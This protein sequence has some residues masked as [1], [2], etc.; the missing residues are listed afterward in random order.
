MRN[1]SL[2]RRLSVSLI[3]LTT[4]GVVAVSLAVSM[5]LGR[6]L[7]SSVDEQLTTATGRP[8][9][10]TQLPPIAVPDT[11]KSPQLPS[12]FVITVLSPDGTALRQ[13]RGSLAAKVPPPDLTG[14]T[15]TFVRA[16]EGEPRTVQGEGGGAPYRAVAYFDARSQQSVVLAISLVPM[17]DTVRKVM[18]ASLGIGLLVVLVLALLVGVV[19]RR[20]LRPLEDV[21]ATAEAIAGGD[22]SQRVADAPPQTEVGPLR[23]RLRRPYVSSSP[24]PATSC[25][26]H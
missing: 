6:Y 8:P 14:Y 13:V 10:G 11:S 18:L 21:E 3:V 24:M 16:H 12:A 23:T 7:M 2:R 4:V 25:E 22:L 20:A 15:A 5:L 19:V 9:A 1:W 17:L 26:R